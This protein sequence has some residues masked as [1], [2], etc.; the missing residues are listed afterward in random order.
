MPITVSPKLRN[1]SLVVLLA[2]S[3]AA[4][5]ILA[6]RLTHNRS[7]QSDCG[8]DIKGHMAPLRLLSTKGQ[9]VDVTYHMGDFPAL[10]YFFSPECP[11][12]E[13]NIDNFYALIAEAPGKYRF[14][15]ISSAPLGDLKA[16]AQRE[17]IDVPLYHILPESVGAYGLDG[18]P[19]TL[20]VSP[21][22]TT[23]AHW[24]GAYNPS[25]LFDIEHTL[26]VHLPGLAERGH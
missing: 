22:G 7:R 10:F 2:F 17:H 8:P 26:T 6:L 12:C 16:Y 3:I 23:L 9:V 4:N 24:E 11:W 18:T 19:S 1:V 15:A 21:T 20:L 14:F 5:L 25:T 13:A